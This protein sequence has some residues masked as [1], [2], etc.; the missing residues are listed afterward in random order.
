MDVQILD[1]NEN[2]DD[3]IFSVKIKE[4]TLFTLCIWTEGLR[5]Q[6]R[7]R[8][9]VAEYSLVMSYR[10]HFLFIDDVSR[11]GEPVGDDRIRCN[12]DE[13][14]EEP[15]V[16]IQ[17][18]QNNVEAVRRESVAVTQNLSLPSQPFAGAPGLNPGSLDSTPRLIGSLDSDVSKNTKQP[19]NTNHPQAQPGDLVKG[20]R[21]SEEFGHI[22]FNELDPG[23]ISNRFRTREGPSGT[24][25]LNEMNNVASH[26]ISSS[27]NSGEEE[28]VKKTP[29]EGNLGFHKTLQLTVVANCIDMFINVVY[30]V[31]TF[32]KLLS[33]VMLN[34][35]RCHTHF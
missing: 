11:R 31:T 29:V 6:C 23:T 19:M 15:A 5:K 4:N 24:S 13:V 8:S 26:R 22:E 7:L 30:F 34:K 35:L 9:D 20:E 32:P 14:R 27:V 33:H 2:Y 17:N 3:P 25:F 18:P 16:A 1:S 21:C 10:K 12:V 28:T